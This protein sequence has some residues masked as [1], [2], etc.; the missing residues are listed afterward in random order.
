MCKYIKQLCQ[1]NTQIELCAF[2]ECVTLRWILDDSYL[3]YDIGPY[4]TLIYCI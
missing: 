1:Q 4:S 3:G 2:C